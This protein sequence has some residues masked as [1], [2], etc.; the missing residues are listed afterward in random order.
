M[1]KLYVTMTDFGHQ[2]VYRGIFGCCLYVGEQ[3]KRNV[4]QAW[5]GTDD[6]NSGQ[7]CNGQAVGR[8]R[9]IKALDILGTGNID[10]LENRATSSTQE[11]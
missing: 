6:G 4:E 11:T 9:D 1:V 8:T 10:G 3:W 7:V 5:P 2:F